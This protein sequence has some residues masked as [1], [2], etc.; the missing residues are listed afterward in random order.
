MGLRD[1]FRV[2]KGTLVY[3]ALEETPNQ[4]MSENAEKVACFNRKTRA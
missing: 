3:N 4:W 2:L 1:M